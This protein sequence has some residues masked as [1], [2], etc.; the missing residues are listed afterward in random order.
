MITAYSSEEPCITL[1]ILTGSAEMPSI[2]LLLTLSMKAIGKLLS[3]PNNTPIFFIIQGVNGMKIYIPMQVIKFIGTGLN[4]KIEY[5]IRFLNE[6][7]Q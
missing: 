4:K 2:F 1:S 5:C 3:C 7:G 6:K